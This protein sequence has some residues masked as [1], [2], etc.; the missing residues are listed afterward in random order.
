M[1]LVDTSVWLMDR[2]RFRLAD[3]V[4]ADQIAVCGTIIQEVLQ[5]ARSGNIQDTQQ[6]LM[7]M[8]LV[9]LPLP[10]NR[11]EYAAEIY[12]NLRVRGVTIRSS[13]DC[14]IAASAILNGI[15]LLHADRDFDYIADIT[16]LRARNINP[17]ASRSR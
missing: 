6:T 1:I 13:N 15:E 9:D 3:V 8:H 2:R 10:L 16:D 14:L 17:S 12:R 11:F 4:G 5:G 7:H